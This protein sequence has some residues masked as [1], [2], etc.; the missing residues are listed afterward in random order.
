MKNSI[1]LFAVLIVMASCHNYK[2]DAQNLLVQK[3]SL[4]TVS[5][6]KDASILEFMNGYNEIQANLDSI[7][8]MENLVNLKSG[9]MQE[10]S[11]GRKMMILED[12]QLINDLLQKNREQIASLQRQL[13]NSNVKSKELEAVKVMLADLQTQNEK[14]DSELSKLNG[15]VQNLNLNSNK[16]SEK[17]IALENDN[18]QKEQTIES[19][20]NEMSKVF[21][22]IGSTKELKEE[23]VLQKVGGFLG[24]GRTPVIENDFKQEYFTVA[25]KRDCNFI[26]LNVKKA[27][28]LSVHSNTSFHIS[29]DIKADTLFIDN[30]NEFWKATK[31]LIVLTD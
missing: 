12:V 18:R 2:K 27:K 20:T 7:L 11:S 3:D 25:D 21:Y 4:L 28:L 17:I 31:Y 6:N 5:E 30:K 29:S 13:K 1:F 8:K 10:M 22:A 19:Q 9:N 14:K 26:P 15:E 23:G 16:L 24:L